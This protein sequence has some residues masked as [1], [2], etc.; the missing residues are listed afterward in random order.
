MEIELQTDCFARFAALDF[1]DFD[2]VFSDNFFDL[3]SAAP[4]RVGIMN[5]RCYGNA[6][7]TVDN[8]QKS[9]RIRTLTDTY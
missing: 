8:L 4:V 3:T 5:I 9:L 6:P 7:V 2:A 1:E